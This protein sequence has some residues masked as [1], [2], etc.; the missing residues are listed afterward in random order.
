M[1][2]LDHVEKCMCEGC[3]DLNGLYSMYTVDRKGRKSVQRICDNKTTAIEALQRYHDNGHFDIY[4]IEGKMSCDHRVSNKEVDYVIE[5][6]TNKTYLYEP[7]CGIM[8]GRRTR[9]L[10]GH[11]Y[12][13]VNQ[14]SITDSAH[15]QSQ[16]RIS[17]PCQ[18]CDHGSHYVYLDRVY[19][20]MLKRGIIEEYPELEETSHGPGF[21]KYYLIV[22]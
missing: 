13:V 17:V 10:Y 7:P 4:V 16:R 3:K 15:S 6:I 19:K 12:D 9:G 1:K 8:R 18:R 21:P 22:K 20:R 14:K 11:I 5:K 2:T